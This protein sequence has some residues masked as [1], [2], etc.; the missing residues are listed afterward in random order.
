LHLVRFTAQTDPE[1]QRAEPS[2]HQHLLHLFKNLVL[3]LP[4][5]AFGSHRNPNLQA[6]ASVTAPLEDFKAGLML[7]LELLLERSIRERLFGIVEEDIQNAL[8]GATFE[9]QT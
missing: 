2:Q 8:S 7:C 5:L 1:E 4:L 9:Y 6:K 3:S